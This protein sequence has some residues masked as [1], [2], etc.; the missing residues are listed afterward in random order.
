MSSSDLRRKCDVEQEGK[1]PKLKGWG[2]EEVAKGRAGACWASQ[3]VGHSRLSYKEHI[4][5]LISLLSIFALDM[6][7]ALADLAWGEIR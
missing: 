4:P 6:L 3:N 5:D 7:A 1:A 2:E